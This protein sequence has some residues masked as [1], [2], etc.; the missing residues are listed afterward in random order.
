MRFNTVVVCGNGLMLI[1]FMLFTIIAGGQ[2]YK[3]GDLPTWYLMI[4][5]LFLSLFVLSILGSRR[6]LKRALKFIGFDSPHKN[7]FI[8]VHDA[9]YR[10]RLIEENPN[11]TE[12]VNWILIT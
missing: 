10:R 1:L 8:A 3:Y 2:Y 11:T 4:S 6:P 12:L 7:V 9:D 5:V